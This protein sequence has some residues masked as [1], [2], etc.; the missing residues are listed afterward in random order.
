MSTISQ[1]FC[2]LGLSFSFASVFAEN[3]LSDLPAVSL[4]HST[5]AAEAAKAAKWNDEIQRLNS[6]IRSENE[7]PLRPVPDFAP[8][9]YLLMSGILKAP[10]YDAT[11]IKMK[12]AQNLPAGMKLILLVMPGEEKKTK[13]QFTQ[14]IA[15]DRLVIATQATAYN[16]F[17]AR[18]AYPYPVYMNSNLDVNLIASRYDREFSGHQA[19]MASI[20]AESIM[21]KYNHVFVGG[22]LLSDENGRCF[23]VESIRL[24]NLTDTTLMETYGCQEV[25]RFRHT[26]GIGDVDEVIK[27]LPNKRVLTNES[28]YVAKLE[29]LGYQVTMLPQLTN[30]R[31]YANSI[32]FGNLVFMP[33][34]NLPSD[35][36]AQMVYESLGYQVIA[37]DSTSLST[38]GLGSIHCATM[39]YPEIDLSRLMRMLGARI[40]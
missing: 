13:S 36:E 9:K 7:R 15:E 38:R 3:R 30:Y 29:A 10:D 40:L 16:G 8:F 2:L 11:E 14:W 18:D 12:I 25:V 33:K 37:A 27:I 31:T 34:F 4:R 6:I 17:W 26:Q 23:V 32:L 24:Y 20:G 19:L 21:R 28:S 39:A 35:Q 1:L 5:T 22:N